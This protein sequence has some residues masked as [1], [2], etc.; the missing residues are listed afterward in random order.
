MTDT[1]PLPLSALIRERTKDAHSSSEGAGFMSSLLRGERS[2]DDY[3]ALVAQHFFIYAALESSADRMREDPIAARFIT[4]RLTRLPAI[5]ADLEFLLGPD[6]RDR[7][8]ALDA[9]ARYATRIEKVAETWP[10]GFVAHHYTRYLGDLSG[11]FHIGRVIKR[12]FG[13][14]TNGARFYVFDDVADP[15]EFKNAYRERLD[16]APWAE[17]ERERVIAEVL[18]AYRF[19][20]EVFEQ[21]AEAR[22]PG[23]VVVG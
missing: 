20:T 18:C 10:G 8:T 19:N 13:F 6:W 15:S 12:Q 17:D 1:T 2:R 9:T 14:D 16:D 23:G 4:N 22:S 11:G 3:I 7:I 5:E 21:L